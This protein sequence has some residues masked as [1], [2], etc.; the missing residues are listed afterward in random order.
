[1]QSLIWVVDQDQL[2]PYV[3]IEGYV[4]RVPHNPLLLVNPK[5]DLYFA[6]FANGVAM[7]S[8]PRFQINFLPT[9]T[10]VNFLA[11]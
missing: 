5:C 8:T 4:V 3:A 10:Q 11:L 1:T 9:F 7:R 6:G 2:N